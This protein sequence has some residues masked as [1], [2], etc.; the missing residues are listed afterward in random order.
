MWKIAA[1]AVLLGTSCAYAQ[2]TQKYFGAESEQGWTKGEWD[3][4][5]GQ[6]PFTTP[7]DLTG[8]KAVKLLKVKPVQAPILVP[9][10]TQKMFGDLLNPVP[11]AKQKPLDSNSDFGG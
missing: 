7:R 4:V 2:E 3:V 6:I 5:T 11:L 9:E 8:N 1:L 10:I